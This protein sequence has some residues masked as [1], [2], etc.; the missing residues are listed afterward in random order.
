MDPGRTCSRTS[1][2]PPQVNGT[3]Q[4]LSPSR[5]LGVSASCANVA[6]NLRGPPSPVRGGRASL[7]SLNLPGS[8]LPGPPSPGR[9]SILVRSPLRGR[10]HSPAKLSPRNHNPLTGKLRTPSPVQKRTGRYSPAR[11]SKSWLGPQRV[12]S[13][14]TEGPE[15][16]TEK[17]LSVPNL[18][19]SVDECR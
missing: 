8:K 10:G 9:R 2:R 6:P 3:V 11:T 16:K 5:S 12:P 14:A 18:I 15:R 1:G 7:G 17:S 4:D 19:V 13:E